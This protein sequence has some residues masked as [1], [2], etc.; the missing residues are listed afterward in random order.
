M[1]YY[2]FTVNFFN[3]NKFFEGEQEFDTEEEMQQY[4][5]G[6][7]ERTEMQ[8]Q[9]YEETAEGEQLVYEWFPEYE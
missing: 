8:V 9:V 6:L 7:A 5:E 3:S 1:K 2:F 4:A